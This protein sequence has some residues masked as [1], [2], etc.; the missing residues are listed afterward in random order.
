MRADPARC[1]NALP[2]EARC[3]QAPRLF[4]HRFEAHP[5]AVRQALHAALER[6][7]GQLSHDRAGTLELVLAEVLNNIVE[8]AY[9]ERG[10][11]PIVLSI[12]PETDALLC[13]IDDCGTALPGRC[14]EPPENTRPRPDDLPEGGF[15][16]FLIR[17]LVRDLHYRREN[18]RNLLIFRLPLDPP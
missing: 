13:M 15:G 11:G 8:H 12:E 5:Q 14:I 3:P 7:G 18:N 16:W 9:E 6:V 17:D 4:C 1:P 2:G 10:C